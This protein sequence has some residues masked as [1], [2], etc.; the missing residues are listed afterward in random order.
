MRR[1]VRLLALAFLVLVVPSG[2]AISG[3]RSSDVI[4][5]ELDRDDSIPLSERATL[6]V[7]Q[8]RQRRKD[9]VARR[10]ELILELYRANPDHER[11]PLLMPERWAILCRDP[12]NSVS[13]PREIDEVLF[14]SADKNLRLAGLS[15]KARV[16]IL[17]P[18]RGKESLRVI[19]LFIQ[20]EG[21]GGKVGPQ[22][23]SL[24]AS[25]LPAESESRA[26]LEGRI[27][28]EYPD[29]SEA[30]MIAGLRRRRAGVGKP[31]D[32][33]FDDAISGS[34]VSTDSMR[35]KVV[36]VDFWA[37][38]C[39]PC[40]EKMPQM[41]ALYERYQSQGVEFIG[42]SLDRSIE[43]GGLDQLKAFVAKN[44]IPWPQ[45]YQNGA[46]T[47]RSPS[48]SESWGV[49]GIPTVFVIDAEGR[50]ASNGTDGPLEKVLSEILAR[51]KP[52]KVN[53][54]KGKK[55]PAARNALPG[56]KTK[57]ASSP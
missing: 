9:Q 18:S 14:K 21:A 42:V 15:W 44:Q 16:L 24:L 3:D 48:F 51:P 41:K 30:T 23:L 27:L 57:G 35:G 8:F 56:I 50:I 22:L 37:T 13:L 39:P 1:F 28:R 45:Y 33:R 5:A 46:P 55:K 4:L 26:K 12:K 19:N 34:K 53:A 20:Q 17:D 54:S 11:I 31:F 38:W 43:N 29:S 52:G 40:I 47:P 6:S 32:L 49:D 10:S 7:E 25:S 36:V 2:V